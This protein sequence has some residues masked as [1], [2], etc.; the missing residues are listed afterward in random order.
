MAIQEDAKGA[1]DQEERRGVR[2]SEYVFA[3]DPAEV[4]A[5]PPGGARQQGSRNARYFFT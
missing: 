2:E 5:G 1:S 4:I 3:Y